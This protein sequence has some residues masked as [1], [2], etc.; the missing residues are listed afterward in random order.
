MDP[1]KEQPANQP[2]TPTQPSQPTSQTEVATVIQDQS[3]EGYF[4]RIFSGRLNRRNYFI[5]ALILLAINSSM[6]IL[7]FYFNIM[8]AFEQ[9]MSHTQQ[10]IPSSTTSLLSMIS[11]P[12][13]FVV[14][15]CSVSLSIRR[16]HDL[17]K[18]GWFTLI[19]FIPIVG[20]F[21]GLYVLLASGTVGQNDYGSQPLPRI[22]F[23]H[24]ILRL[25]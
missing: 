6:Q 15:F 11:T 17:N 25:T 24:D 13:S 14:I 19:M 10:S 12:I 21:Y 7:L 3:V 16:L 4:G 18:T 22:D 23:K 1:Q 5:G 8:P 2:P 20:V 9:Y